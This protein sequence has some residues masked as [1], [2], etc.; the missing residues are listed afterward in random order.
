MSATPPDRRRSLWTYYERRAAGYDGSIAGTY[1]YFVNA[2]VDADPTVIA[3][4]RDAVRR[5]LSRLPPM[6]F[7][8]VGA[9]PG[10][11]TSLIPG[12]G[13]ALDQSESALRRLRA[14]IP[15]VP[16]LR[17]DASAL[18][19]ATKAVPRVFA[20]H[21]YGHLEEDDRSTFLGEAAASRMSS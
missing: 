8:D 11:F 1:R 19:I 9:G 15:G 3:A 16:V 10:V 18:P 6:S 17:G 14:E 21:L 12:Q 2:G 7:I 20:A 5:E 13:V 4:E